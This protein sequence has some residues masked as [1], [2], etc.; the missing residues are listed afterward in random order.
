VSTGRC[1]DLGGNEHGAGSLLEQRRGR[2]LA[3]PRGALRA[4]AGP[5]HRAPAA[6]GWRRVRRLGRR[7]RLRHGVHHPS[8]RRAATQGQALGVDLSAAMHVAVVGISAW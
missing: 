8:R 3:G 1:G 2:A 7:H 5:V 4:H 6:R